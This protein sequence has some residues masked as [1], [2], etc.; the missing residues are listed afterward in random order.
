M[1]RCSTSLATEEMQ[2][3]TTM[4]YHLTPVRMAITNQTSN[5]KCWRGCGEKGTLIHWWWEWKLVWPLWKTVWLFLKKLKIELPYDSAISFS[6]YLPKK[7][8]TCIHNDVCA[9]MCIAPLF[10][11]AKTWRQPV[12]QQILD[13]EDEVHI[14]YGILLSHKKRWNTPFAT[15]WMDLE[16]IILSQIC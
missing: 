13:K 3:K 11:V 14:Y 15:T 12:L 5:N 1:K 16:N 7:L 8:K 2:I 9:P 10:T 6:G 4:R